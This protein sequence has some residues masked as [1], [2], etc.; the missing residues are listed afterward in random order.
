MVL[1]PLSDPLRLCI[2]CVG[3]LS[4]QAA[5]SLSLLYIRGGGIPISRLSATQ[6]WA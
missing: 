1:S 4:L 3:P 6:Y 2:L 5:D